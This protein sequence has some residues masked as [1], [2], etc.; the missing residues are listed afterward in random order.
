MNKSEA[1]RILAFGLA[2]GVM[3]NEP[4]V[5]KES[6]IIDS[7]NRKAIPFNK[8]DGVVNM[9]KDYNLIKQGKSKKRIIKQS[10]IKKKD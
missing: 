4:S 8:H 3:E 2:M 1:M 5:V 10:R 6:S 7:R 9:I